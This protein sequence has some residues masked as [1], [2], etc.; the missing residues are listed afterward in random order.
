MIHKFGSL[1]CFRQFQFP[2]KYMK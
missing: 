1:P 2:D